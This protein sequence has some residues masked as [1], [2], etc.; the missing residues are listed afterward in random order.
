MPPLL[1]HFSSDLNL[2]K[3]RFAEFNSLCQIFNIQSVTH[4]AN[5]QDGYPFVF[6]RGMSEE[7]AKQFATRE[8]MLKFVI[9]LSCSLKGFLY[10]SRTIIDVWADAPTFEEAFSQ[11]SKKSE[12][13]YNSEIVCVV[14]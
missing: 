1:F 3:F 10:F 8:F 12:S 9:Y 11:L 2:D 6:V 13:E 5:P 4:D 14:C 7:T